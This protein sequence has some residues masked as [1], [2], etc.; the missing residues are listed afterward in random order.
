VAAPAPG[1]PESAAPAGSRR[2]WLIA[3]VVLAVL[4]VA[5]AAVLISVVKQP[6]YEPVPI[7]SVSST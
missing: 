2:R 7:P 3:L 1:A 6:T 4:L 5:S